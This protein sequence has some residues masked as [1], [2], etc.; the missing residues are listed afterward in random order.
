[1]Q[2]LLGVR[3]L[4]QRIDGRHRETHS[5]MG[6]SSRTPQGLLV[7]REPRLLHPNRNDRDLWVRKPDYGVLD[8]GNTP[9]HGFPLRVSMDEQ[10][11]A[12]IMIQRRVDTT[13]QV[14]WWVWQTA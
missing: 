14:L 7:D 13:A 5:A 11:V 10:Q 9:F 12:R 2:Y 6:I 8:L 3:D 4:L 1:M